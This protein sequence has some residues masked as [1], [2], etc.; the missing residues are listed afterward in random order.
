MITKNNRNA[1]SSKTVS[2]ITRPYGEFEIFYRDDKDDLKR[3][4]AKAKTLRGAISKAKID[5]SRIVDAS[6]R[7][8]TNDQGSTNGTY[9][10]VKLD[11]LDRVM[12]V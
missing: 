6:I 12:G 7:C 2:R 3:V 1:H 5:V 11:D 8:S 10:A 4:E 9:Q